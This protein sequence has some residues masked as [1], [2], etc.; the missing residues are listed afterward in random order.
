MKIADHLSLG[1]LLVSRNFECASKVCKKL[2]MFGNIYPD[3]NVTSYLRGTFAHGE[4]RG[5]NFE[6]SL[7]R[8]KKLIKKLCKDKGRSRKFGFR[9]VFR[10]GE[11][12]H[13][14]ADAFTLPH[15]K[16]FKGDLKAHVAY[17]KRLHSFFEMV[18]N[19]NPK[20]KL[21]GMCADSGKNGSSVSTS[22][23]TGETHFDLLSEFID[24]HDSYIEAEIEN[25]D[26]A[27][28]IK[29]ILSSIQLVVNR[30]FEFYGC[31]QELALAA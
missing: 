13:Y 5:H 2:F 10:L 11:L 4:V 12:V 18:Q 9:K 20:G 29:Y 8:I 3:I 19:A 27:L 31:G 22:A 25:H 21:L 24:L 26:Y 16:C 15:N 23:K 6:H 30:V 28:D 14:T 1:R 17:E 7:K